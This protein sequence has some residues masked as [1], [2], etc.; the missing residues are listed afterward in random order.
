MQTKIQKWGN[1]L[2]LRI[3]RS[4]AAEAQVSE[5]ATVDLSVENGRLLVRPLRVRKYSLNRLVRKV[6]PAWRGLDRETSRARGLVVAAYVPARGDL[7]WLQFNPQAGHEQAGHRPAVVIS[8]SSYNRRVGLAL[9]CPITSQVK[10]YPFEVLLP[11]GLGVEGAI[12]SD[13][14]KSLDWRVRKARRI[15]SLPADLLLEAAGKILA[16]VDPDGAR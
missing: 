11:Q 3:P 2:G 12:L 10:G 4:F 6:K 7:I 15:G 13:Q 9:C 16:L 8:P 1:S 14:I 5:G